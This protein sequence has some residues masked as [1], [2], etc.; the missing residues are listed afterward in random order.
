MIFELKSSPRQCLLSPLET[1]KISNFSRGGYNHPIG[2]VLGKFNFYTLTDGFRPH[3]AQFLNMI[4]ELK[5]KPTT[6]SSFPTEGER[7]VKY[8]QGWLKLLYMPYY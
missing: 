4:F 8:L 5:V 6:G 3:R 7:F 1:K 2:S